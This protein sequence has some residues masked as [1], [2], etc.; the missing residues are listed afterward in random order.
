MQSNTQSGSLVPSGNATD[1][2]ARCGPNPLC[3]VQA[4]DNQDLP[5]KNQFTNKSLT[6]DLLNSIRGRHSMVWI[7]GAKEKQH[8][9]QRLQMFW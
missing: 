3:W 7:P 5:S 8:M 2:S 4:Y 9:I 6:K 1:V